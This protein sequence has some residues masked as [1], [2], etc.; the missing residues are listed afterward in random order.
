MAATLRAA[1]REHIGRTLDLGRA[2]RP[3]YRRASGPARVRLGRARR[4]RG[5]DEQHERDRDARAA[6]G[7]WSWG[8]LR[9]FLIVRRSLVNADDPLDD[10]RRGRV[11]RPR[12]RCASARPKVWVGAP[13][14]WAGSAAAELLRAAR[15]LD[16]RV[17]AELGVDVRHVRADGL[18]ADEQPRGD[19]AVREPVGEQPAAP[20]PRASVRPD[21]VVVA[22]RAR[23]APRA[24]SS[25]ARRAS[26]SAASRSGPRAERD[27]GGVRGG[28]RCAPRRPARRRASSVA[29]ASCRRA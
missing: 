2:R 1:A 25:R 8:T 15:R 14:R 22:A 24:R 21:A 9:A 3:I 12:Q 17:H 10:P 11:P 6:G 28:E 13:P 29:S 5:D 4:G 7:R 16:A 18:L 23:S 26:A 19:L 27:R 20:R